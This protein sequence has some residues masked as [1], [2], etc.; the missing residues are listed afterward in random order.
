MKTTTMR[1]RKR[2][3]SMSF[4]HFSTVDD[5]P[6]HHRPA[7][8]LD[9]VHFLDNPHSAFISGGSPGK[10]DSVVH[11]GYEKM[12]TIP[13]SSTTDTQRSSTTGHTNGRHRL[14]RLSLVPSD[15]CSVSSRLSTPLGDTSWRRINEG[16]SSDA[17]TG[18][19]E[20]SDGIGLGV[21][22]GVGVGSG[23]ERG[24][25]VGSGIERGV[26]VDSGIER[27]GAGAE[28]V[29]GGGGVGPSPPRR[30]RGMA[31]R[32]SISYSP[33]IR[34]AFPGV[35]SGI[36]STPVRHQHPSSSNSHLQRMSH[37]RGGRDDTGEET[38]KSPTER[39]SP[40]WDRRNSTT[41]DRGGGEK[42]GTS[43][44]EAQRE[45][46]EDMRRERQ[47]KRGETLVER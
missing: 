7:S 43:G 38:W 17:D 44:E 24:V 14:K 6:H 15:Y 1:P 32:S 47:V 25:G 12:N 20:G 26:G 39:H 9:I 11:V 19:A 23:V 36:P 13:S 37:H 3:D 42:M 29:G 45:Q 35:P 28:G 40:Q 22:L 27:G 46:G 10:K 18:S 41:I 30:K 21:G 2:P 31:V 16:G 5:R 34:S 4:L 33:A 8:S